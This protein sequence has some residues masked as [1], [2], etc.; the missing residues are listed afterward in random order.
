MPHKPHEVLSLNVPWLSATG[1]TAVSVPGGSFIGGVAINR[2]VE[3][4]EL[5]AP[6]DFDTVVMT[7]TVI[8]LRSFG[9]SVA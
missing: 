3:I 4:E 1:V 6:C 2:W 8:Q 7:G 9:A 5:S